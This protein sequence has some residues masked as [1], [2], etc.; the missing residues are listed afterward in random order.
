MGHTKKIIDLVE[1]ELPLYTPEAQEENDIPK[2]IKELADIFTKSEAMIFV[3]P[4]YNGG[5]P[6]TLTNVIAS[7]S[8]SGNDWR[9][10]FSG[11]SA[12]IATHSGGG[13]QYVLLAIRSQLSIYRNECSRQTNYY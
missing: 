8:V 2:K 11:K 4:E 12:M 13:G 3:A 6:P 7:L 1:Q 10:C 5:I 9:K